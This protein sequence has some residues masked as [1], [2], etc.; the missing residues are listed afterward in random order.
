MM[1][2]ADWVARDCSWSLVGVK[3]DLSAW[4]K[5]IAN[6]HPISALL[7][8]EKARAAAAD[9]FVTGSFWYASSPMAAGLETLKLVNNTDYLERIERLGLQLR[10][11]LNERA[12][13]AGFHLRQTGPVQMPLFLFDDDPDLR[14]GFSGAAKCCTAGCMCTLGITCS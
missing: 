6:G 7:G 2:A 14:L 4:G 8:S 5:C 9:I 13:K 10:D 12:A 1:F 3:P 11:G